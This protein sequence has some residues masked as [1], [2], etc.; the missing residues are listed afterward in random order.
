[1][2]TKKAYE[3]I[4][5]ETNDMSQE[6]KIP[7]KCVRYKPQKPVRWVKLTKSSSWWKKLNYQ[8]LDARV[9]TPI[10]PKNGTIYVWI[11][12]RIGHIHDVN[13]WVLWENKNVSEI[14]KQ[15]QLLLEAHKGKQCKLNRHHLLYFKECYSFEHGRCL[16]CG[17]EW[18]RHS[19]P[20][21]LLE[22]AF[23]ST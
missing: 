1:M 4:K 7:K 11:D 8:G 20:I 23:R 10:N 6:R 18:K 22:M 19:E 13:G 21:S 15:F 2:F 14:P 16:H 12:Y 17:S 5:D 9:E 3:L